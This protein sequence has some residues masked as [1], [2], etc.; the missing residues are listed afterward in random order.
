MWSINQYIYKIWWYDR[1]PFQPILIALTFYPP[2]KNV[3][4]SPWKNCN[5]YKTNLWHRRGRGGPRTESHPSLLIFCPVFWRMNQSFC[6]FSLLLSRLTRARSCF[7]STIAA[8]S[9]THSTFVDEGS[10]RTVGKSRIRHNSLPQTPFKF[11]F[12][13][14]SLIQ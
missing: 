5:H 6:Q 14:L 9:W 3:N 11:C 12:D 10:Q 1:L 7:I 13:S 2:Q 8:E 4:L